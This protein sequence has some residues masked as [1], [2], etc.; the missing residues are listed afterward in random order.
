[1]HI[2]AVTQT[3]SKWDKPDLLV[4]AGLNCVHGEDGGHGIEGGDEDSYLTDPYCQ[5][6]SPGGLTIGLPMTKDLRKTEGPDSVL[7][8]TY[9]IIK[10]KQ[11]A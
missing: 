5:Q 6:Q 3:E 4:S 10:A 1:M 11:S 8:Q 2:R 9:R 7:I